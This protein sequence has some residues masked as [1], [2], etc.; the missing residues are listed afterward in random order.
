MVRRRELQIKWVDIERREWH[1][2]CTC[3]GGPAESAVKPLFRNWS[4][5]RTA[6]RKEFFPELIDEVLFG[7]DAGKREWR[8]FCCG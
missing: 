1:L 6:I 7:D 8:D 2:S 4:R 3:V 5:E